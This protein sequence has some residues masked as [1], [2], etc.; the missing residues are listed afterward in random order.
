MYALYTLD[1]T[2]K[3][4]KFLI[5]TAMKR[6]LSLLSTRTDSVDA[7]IKRVTINIF[8]TTATT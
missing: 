5:Y 6:T 2:T 1:Q 3:V 4:F 7:R 8:T